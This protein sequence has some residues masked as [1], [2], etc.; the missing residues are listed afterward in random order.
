MTQMP[1]QTGDE[2]DQTKMSREIVCV[3]EYREGDQIL[4]TDHATFQN[5]TAAREETKR[6]AI[7]MVEVFRT[8]ADATD[9]VVRAVDLDGNVIAAV[10]FEEA[11]QLSASRIASMDDM[12]KSSKEG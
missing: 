12:P 7:H 5:L 1:P 3:L 10:S 11:F 4:R 8:V 9:W 6:S 2:P